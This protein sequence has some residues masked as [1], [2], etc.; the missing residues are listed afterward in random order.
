MPVVALR[1]WLS[2]FRWPLAGLAALV[3]VLACVLVVPQWLVGWELGDAVR[4]LTADQ[5]AKAINDVRTTLL[6][7]IG[8]AAILVGI[9]FTYR[10]L[11]TG[12]EQLQIAQQGQVTERFTRA[13]RSTWQHL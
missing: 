1:R 8:G 2:T 9:Y 11:Q 6:Q 7:G 10:Q 3:V 5:E 13:G 4:E 12:R